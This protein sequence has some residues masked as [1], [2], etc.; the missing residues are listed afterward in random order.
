MAATLGHVTLDVIVRSQDGMIDE[1]VG[2]LT[3]PLT[4]D[5]ELVSRPQASD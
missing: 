4:V 5:V 2:E 3:I 1:K